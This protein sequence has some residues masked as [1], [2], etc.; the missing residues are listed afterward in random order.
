MIS[1]SL[2]RIIVGRHDR[3][4]V[5]FVRRCMLRQP[6]CVAASAVPMWMITGTRDGLIERAR[7]R[8]ACARH[9]VA[10]CPVSRHECRTPAR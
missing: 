1:Y 10:A 5:G 3:H 6:H 9:G 7:R 4:C 2:Y 8:I